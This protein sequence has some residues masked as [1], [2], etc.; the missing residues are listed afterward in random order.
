MNA[1]KSVELVHVNHGK[2]FTNTLVIAEQCKV[3]H[4]TVIGH[5][6]K[7]KKRFEELDP[8]R[9]EIAK[10]KKLAQ[11]GFA[12]STEY[13]ELTE[14]QATVLITML[15]NTD[16]VLDF[17]FALVKAFR[18]AINEINRIKSDPIRKDAL[19]DKRKSGSMMCESFKFLRDLENK[20]TTP[21]HYANEYKFCWRALTG[22]WEKQDES[23]L[24]AYDLRLLEAIRNRNQILMAL[25][26]KQADRKQLL[27]DFVVEYR[28][29]KP[30]L[31]LVTEKPAV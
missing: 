12:K 18:K 8:I 6:R 28:K 21:N 7:H 13:A 4:E 10:G 31:S 22:N 3:G 29:K 9:F 23:T 19:I 2:V 25:H 11:G 30:R 1:Q 5:V 15:R 14:D 20:A 16:V 27:D 24:D 17:K 26:P